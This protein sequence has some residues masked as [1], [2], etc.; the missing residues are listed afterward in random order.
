MLLR[1]LAWGDL[2]RRPRHDGQA[3]DLREDAFGGDNAEGKG[4]PANRRHG[5][6][7]TQTPIATNQ[8]LRS[9]TSEAQENL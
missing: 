3:E 4:H 5:V 2:K 9:G 1:L 6:C 8:L 7:D